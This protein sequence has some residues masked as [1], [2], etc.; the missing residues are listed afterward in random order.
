[1]FRN[2]FACRFIKLYRTNNT[3]DVIRVQSFSR[4]LIKFR[5]HIKQIFTAFFLCRLLQFFTKFVIS[6]NLTECNVI[7]NRIYIKSRTA[8]HYGNFAA[9][10]NIR[11]SLMC[12]LGIVRNTE[13]IIRFK[14]TDKM[15]NGLTH[16]FRSRFCRAYIHIFINLHTVGTDDFTADII[17]NI[18]R[19]CRFSRCGRSDNNNKRYL[20][21]FS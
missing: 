10:G 3:S 20:R 18:N 15:M 21:Q 7:Y 5:K 13:L 16:F 11:D 1:M 2:R 9:A 17:C 19:K 6:V 14:K 12:K 8:C 4:L